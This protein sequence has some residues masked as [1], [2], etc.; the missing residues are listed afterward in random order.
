MSQQFGEAIVVSD[1]VVRRRGRTVVD[2]VNFSARSGEICCL[3][4]PNGA[5]KTTTIETLEGYLRP[6]S[7]NV[8]VLGLD[9]VRERAQLA[10]RLG[11]ALQ[12]GGT[13]PQMSPTRALR[14]FASYYPS[15]AEPDELIS[16]LG[17]SEVAHVPAKRLSGGQRRRL[18]LS[19]ALVGRPRVVLL[20]EPTAGVDP[21]G[22]LAVR[23]VLERLRS[24]GVCVL[25][26]THELEEAE[27]LADRVV[28]LVAGRVVASGAP[29]EL[30][31]GAEE[32]RFG[33]AAGLDL[34]SLS[35]RLEAVVTEERTGEY[36]VARAPEPAA[37]ATLTAW[38]AERDVVLGELRAGRRRLEEVFL[39][40][41]TRHEDTE[42]PA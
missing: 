11:V 12:E 25:L 16:L 24:E 20:D 21:E 31:G 39:D 34:D 9:P 38:L 37:I 29:E 15:P 6:D 4:G 42:H 14:L 41:I 1:L 26:T 30:G 8:T 17:L 5:G 28:L 2:G 13:Y 7:G 3:L 10:L 35:S 18:A 36:R 40:L 27:R 32:I 19:L 22:R 23:A 33:A